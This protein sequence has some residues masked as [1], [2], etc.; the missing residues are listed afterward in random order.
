MGFVPA[1]G[2]SG[3]RHIRLALPGVQE[4]LSDQGEDGFR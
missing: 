1:S 3:M 2:T 4:D